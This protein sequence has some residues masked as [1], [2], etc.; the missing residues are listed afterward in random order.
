MEKNLSK[1]DMS[2]EALEWLKD[3]RETVSGNPRVY[4]DNTRNTI[5]DNQ[6]KKA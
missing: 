4:L 2:K 1:G 6:G 5:E 3:L